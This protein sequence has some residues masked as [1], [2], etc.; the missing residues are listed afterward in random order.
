MDRIAIAGLSLNELELDLL[1]LA[2]ARVGQ[3]ELELARELLDALGASDLV[4]LSTCNRMEVVYA[5]EEGHR[6]SADDL[7]PI[8]DVLGLDGT[9][10]ASAARERL[11]FFRGLAAAR[12]LFRVAAS[13]DSLV[14]GEGEIL[15]Q[16]RDAY[17]RADSARLCGQLLGPLFQT[18]LQVGKQVRSDTDLAKHPVSVVSIAV[19]RLAERFAGRSP[20]I[21]VVGAG[22]MGEL[23]AKSLSNERLAPFLFANRSLERAPFLAAR[24]GGNA[25]DLNGL[26]RAAVD[27]LLSATSAPGT[28]LNAH[29]LRSLSGRAPLGSGL[30]AADLAVPRDLEPCPD[31]SVEILDLEKLR[32]LS[33]AN[34]VRRARS[35]AQAEKLIE[36]K[37]EVF[38]RRCHS[39]VLSD[40]IEE[41]QAETKGILEREI[42]QLHRERLADLAPE[43]RRA[44]ERWARATFGRLA[45]APVSALKRLATDPSTENGAPDGSPEERVG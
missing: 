32:S 39:R 17:Q 33:E 27:A 42:A 24:Y 11:H 5:R 8:A 9:P 25:M 15:A 14:V 20:R 19:R 26:R 23:I 38:A 36:H 31:P 1:E 7:G 6:P 4:L 2:K 3:D 28:I 40:A 29:A 41:L 43:Q 13:L 44:V 35:A 12:H 34:R 22:A 21:A 10:R 37:L 16:V 45:H 18:A 30:F